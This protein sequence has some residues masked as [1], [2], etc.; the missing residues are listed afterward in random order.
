MREILI[1]ALLFAFAQIGIAQE[2]EFS[3][4][5]GGS[6]GK[7]ITYNYEHSWPSFYHELSDIQEFSFETLINYQVYDRVGLRAGISYA[8]KGHK[9]VYAWIAP[10]GS[11]GTGDPAIPMKSKIRLKYIDVPLGVY[12]Q[13]IR[14]NR[15]S[16]SPS[17]GIMN[18]IKIGESEISEMG[19]GKT[20]KRSSYSFDRSSYELGARLGLIN[21]FN[22]SEKIF[23]SV[24]PFLIYSLSKTNDTVIKRSDFTFG[25]CL[26]VNYRFNKK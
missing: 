13:I 6:Y 10:D 12:Y 26:S 22:L 14:T 21:N 11:D 24:E 25:G 17:I 3:I 8:C 5:F 1:V 23:I 15:Y 9:V 18:S 7:R 19:D 4:G 16:F 20:K 2:N